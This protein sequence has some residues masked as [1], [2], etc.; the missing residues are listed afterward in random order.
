ML[1]GP[2]AIAF[3]SAQLKPF[4]GDEQPKTGPRKFA[5]PAAGRAGLAVAD[6][7]LKPRA[8]AIKGKPSSTG[9]GGYHRWVRQK[10]RGMPVFYQK[11]EE[12]MPVL[13]AFP[14]AS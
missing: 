13:T 1:A 6:R 14:F 8:Q 4:A 9:V 10:R 7:Q 11:I 12:K 3:R 2:F 5:F